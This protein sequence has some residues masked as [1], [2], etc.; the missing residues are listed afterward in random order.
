MTELETTKTF[1]LDVLE[2]AHGLEFKFGKYL[3]GVEFVP[4][5]VPSNPAVKVVEPF[6]M[7][8]VALIRDYVI[9]IV[10]LQCKWT[11]RGEDWGVLL[12][13]FYDI[14]ESHKPYVEILNDE[15]LLFLNPLKQ[16]VCE[17]L[18]NN[19]W[20]IHFVKS[21]SADIIIE[22]ACDYRVYDW[23]RRMQNKGW[24]DVQFTSRNKHL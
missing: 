17:F 15:V 16:Q 10:N 11:K 2:M 3:K 5:I 13:R 23:T 12:E 7:T 19:A 20:M 9:N 6:P 4:A 14:D 8:G 21:N 18:G 22:T 24:N 1:V